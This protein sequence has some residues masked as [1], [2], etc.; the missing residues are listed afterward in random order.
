MMQED[1]TI[2]TYRSRG[3]SRQQAPRLLLVG[4]ETA[5]KDK[6]SAKLLSGRR[7]TVMAKSSSLLEAIACL[8]SKGSTW[9]C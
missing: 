2:R 4:G 6:A 8:D 3:P 5:F 7:F 1:S 9:F